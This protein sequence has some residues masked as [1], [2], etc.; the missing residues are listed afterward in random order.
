MLFITYVDSKG[1]ICGR[2]FEV[3]EDRDKAEDFEL[4]YVAVG[5]ATI[6]HLMYCSKLMMIPLV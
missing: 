5:M 4:Y 6:S 2:E 1:I 3:Y